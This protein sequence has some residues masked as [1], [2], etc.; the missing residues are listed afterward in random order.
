MSFV[1]ALRLL[2]GRT[3]THQLDAAEV[4]TSAA[5]GVSGT[6]ISAPLHDERSFRAGGARRPGLS[7]AMSRPTNLRRIPLVDGYNIQT[8]QELLR[9]ADVSTTMI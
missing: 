8:V 6:R 7:N 9:D 4:H 1:L 3:A 2:H 5:V